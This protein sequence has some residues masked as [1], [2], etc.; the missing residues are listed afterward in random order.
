MKLKF[1]IFKNKKSND[2]QPDYRLSYKDGEEWFNCASVYINK[3]KNGA[4]Y[5]SVTL[6]TDLIQ[7][8]QNREQNSNYRKEKK[9]DEVYVNPDDINF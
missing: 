9:Q 4:E 7:K 1:P 8:Y 2:K 3:S 5:L 6:D